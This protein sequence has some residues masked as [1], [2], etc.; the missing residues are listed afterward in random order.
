MQVQFKQRFESDVFA[1]VSFDTRLINA[2]FHDRNIAR[3]NWIGLLRVCVC[4]CVCVWV[5]THLVARAGK[6]AAG[7]FYAGGSAHSRNAFTSH[8]GAYRTIPTS[9][10][11]LNSWMGTLGADATPPCLWCEI[12]PAYQ[13]SRKRKSSMRLDDIIATMVMVFAIWITS[14][15]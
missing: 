4:V 6:Q 1:L 15:W 12:P 3:R 5:L 13:S 14:S 10:E 2:H 8:S 11:R 9:E 7:F